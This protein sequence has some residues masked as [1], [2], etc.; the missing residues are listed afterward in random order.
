M[1]FGWR[2]PLLLF[3][4][5][6]LPVTRDIALSPSI[7]SPYGRK[8]NKDGSILIMALTSLDGVAK[9]RW[10]YM[11]KEAYSLSTFHL[12][13]LL[14]QIGGKFGIQSY[15][16]KS[17]RF[18]GYYPTDIFLHGTI[19]SNKVSLDLHGAFYAI[20]TLNPLTTS[21]ILALLLVCYGIRP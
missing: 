12:R 18:S 1:T 13:D 10:I 20:C 19:F 16:P 11:V 15:G 7:W 6:K 2:I 3:D 5:G 9:P 8:F 17:L 4:N 21:W 14:S